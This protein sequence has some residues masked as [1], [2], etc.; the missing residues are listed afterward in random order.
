VAAAGR[1]GNQGGCDDDGAGRAGLELRPQA[2]LRDE[3]DRVAARS[4]ER[5][6]ARD[7]LRGVSPQFSAQRRNDLTQAN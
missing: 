5:C 1:G 7:R 6:D 2:R 4:L 3:G